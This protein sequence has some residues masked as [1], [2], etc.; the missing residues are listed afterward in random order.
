MSN[1]EQLKHQVETTGVEIRE[2]IGNKKLSESAEE[3]KQLA[4]RFSKS[5]PSRLSYTIDPNSLESTSEKELRALHGDYETVVTDLINDLIDTRVEANGGDDFSAISE[6]VGVLVPPYDHSRYH[7][8]S[9][10]SLKS[11]EERLSAP[12]VACRHQALM[13]AQIANNYLKYKQNSEDFSIDVVMFKNFEINGKPSPEGHFF[14][15]LRNGANHGYIDI[16]NPHLTT[17]SEGSGIIQGT[18]EDATKD[19]FTTYNNRNINVPE[20]TLVNFKDH[21]ESIIKQEDYVEKA[22]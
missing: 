6:V 9:A 21:S 1:F 16:T 18:F 2:G 22:A 13:A 11:I 10:D 20:M 7:W 15:H 5:A 8:S 12:G 3:I 19:L 14:V 17:N 4:L